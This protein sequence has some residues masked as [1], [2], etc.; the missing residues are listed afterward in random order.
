MIVT[1]PS[2]VKSS[3]VMAVTWSA[4][5]ERG[6][7]IPLPHR[8]RGQVRGSQSLSPI[9]GEGRVRGRGQG[10]GAPSPRPSLTGGGKDSG[11][12]PSEIEVDTDGRAHTLPNCLA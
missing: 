8:G 11:G 2:P 3:G 7:A 12:A 9:G 4:V 6:E 5:G 1:P 10:E